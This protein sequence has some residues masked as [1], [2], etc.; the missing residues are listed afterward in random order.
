M[1]VYL[2]SIK[3]VYAY[4]VFT[5]SKKF[6]LRR[7]LG[8]SVERGDRVI[9][10]VTGR[11]KAVMG[12]FTAGRVIRGRPEY[13]WKRLKAIGDTGVSGEDYRYIA[14]S[15][16]AMAI[17]VVDP[18]MYRQPIRLQALRRVF[19]DFNPPMSMR[20]LDPLDPVVRMVFDKA[21]EFS[22][23]MDA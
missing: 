7:F 4:R 15:R 16:D 13:V 18:L 8:L 9:L 17:E 11:V 21:R 22:S 12:E 19:P 23:S 3:P 10:Y 1:Q 2:F 14:G 20:L 5:G 6:E